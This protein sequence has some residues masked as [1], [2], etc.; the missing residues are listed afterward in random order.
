MLVA[1]PQDPTAGKVLG[2]ARYLRGME[3][4]RDNEQVNDFDGNNYHPKP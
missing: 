2:T 1:R 4:A 3:A